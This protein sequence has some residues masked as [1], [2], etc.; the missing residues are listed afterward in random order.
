M[1]TTKL[2]DRIPIKGAIKLQERVYAAGAL[3][4]LVAV[5][6]FAGSEPL[7]GIAAG[8]FSGLLFWGGSCIKTHRVRVI[9][10]GVY[11]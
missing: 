5:G 3:S 8:A 10:G 1:G 2:P 7:F 9:D 11:R 6:G 4:A